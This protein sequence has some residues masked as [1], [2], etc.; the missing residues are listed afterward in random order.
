MLAKKLLRKK[1]SLQDIY[2]LYQVVIRVPKILALLSELEN[3]TIENVLF[4]P[5]KDNVAVS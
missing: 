2:R 3:S 1:A 4:K 5:I